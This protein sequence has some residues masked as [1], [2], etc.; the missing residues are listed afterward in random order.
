[1]IFRVT[2]Q[3]KHLFEDVFNEHGELVSKGFFSQATDAFR[4]HNTIG[5]EDVIMDIPSYFA[6]LEK[7]AK[8]QGGDVLK[9]VS[10]MRVPPDEPRFKIDADSRMIT[11]PPVW[12]TNGLGAI[13]VVGDEAAE[14]VFFEIDRFFDGVD[15]SACNC[16]IEWRNAIAMTNPTAP[17]AISKRS[18]G[19]WKDFDDSKVIF[20]WVVSSDMTKTA[21][22]VQ[23]AVRLTQFVPEVDED[24]Q[25]YEKMVFNFNTQPATIQIKGGLGLDYANTQTE[26]YDTLWK[27]RAHVYSGVVN[28]AWGALPFIEEDLPIFVN[29]VNGEYVL[30]V[31]A[32]SPDNGQLIYIWYKD[33]KAQNTEEEGKAEGMHEFSA[34]IA[35]SYYV[36]VGNKSPGYDVARYR[37]SQTCVIPAAEQVYINEML[38]VSK[39]YATIVEPEDGESLL[40]IEQLEVKAAAE[41]GTLSYQWYKDGVA[42]E[43]A[44]A[45]VYI[46]PAANT[47]QGEYYVEV[48]N[49][50]NNTHTDATSQTLPILL[51][52]WPK[53]IGNNEIH[54]ENYEDPNTFAKG[55]KCIVDDDDEFG[56]PYDGLE[57]IWEYTVVDADNVP[58]SKRVEKA[59]QTNIFIPDASMS[60]MSYVSVYVRQG[61]FKNYGDLYRFSKWTRSDPH[62]VNTVE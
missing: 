45:A 8:E 56:R 53:V 15:L 2:E 42:I 58:T 32:S 35:G 43:G 59:N 61:K 6:A 3:N 18:Y 52:A 17:G 16:E 49:D 12:D 11:V 19:L 54:I 46:V 36:K 26:K 47:A 37:D 4:G 5:P 14:V 31:D 51:M 55:F 28:N 22:Q 25:T 24:G 39:G 44:T 1:M 7:F 20:G 30:S 9:N 21:G 27:S 33:G 29:L 34:D 38:P 48:R 40:R 60:D 10:V 57:Y 41:N 13:G 23:F 50:L 62:P